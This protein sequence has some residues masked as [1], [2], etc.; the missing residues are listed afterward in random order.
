[1][2]AN[3]TT[4]RENVSYKDVPQGK[5]SGARCSTAIARFT[6]E[7]YTLTHKNQ[8][9]VIGQ[10]S[11]YGVY[12]SYF[13][14]L[15]ES[16]PVPIKFYIEPHQYSA[17]LDGDQ[18]HPVR[19]LIGI[20]SQPHGPARLWAG[21]RSKGE[22]VG[23]IQYFTTVGDNISA[24]KSFRA[25]DVV[26][27]GPFKLLEG[28]AGPA[29][30]SPKRSLRHAIALFIRLAL[31]DT[32][33]VDGFTTWTKSRP[34]IAV[35][36]IRTAVNNNVGLLASKAPHHGVDAPVA[37]PAGKT[38]ATNSST[39]PAK[40]LNTIALCLEAQ[41]QPERSSSNVNGKRPLERCSGE[42]YEQEI[43]QDAGCVDEKKRWRLVRALKYN[44]LC[45]SC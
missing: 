17:T 5:Q 36:H 42:G 32:G 41:N 9:T 19:I 37:H 38:A 16:L 14:V 31:L 6:C 1:M 23:N 2:N 40:V 29:R 22:R 39:S 34:D 27:D 18:L 15:R 43:A 35:E 3:T 44:F 8:P 4:G 7:S 45:G 25:Q 10:I 33:R 12:A 20:I 13:E 26:F 11:W 21:V 24:V 28:V 30:Y